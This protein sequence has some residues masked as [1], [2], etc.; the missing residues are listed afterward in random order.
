MVQ[1]YADLVSRS[2]CLFLVLIFRGQLRRS[3]GEESTALD[4]LEDSTI[5][6]TYIPGSRA[7]T[8]RWDA[9]NYYEHSYHRELQLT[10]KR[11]QQRSRCRTARIHPLLSGRSFLFPA[12]LPSSIF[13]RRSC[14]TST[15]TECTSVDCLCLSRQAASFFCVWCA[16]RA[17]FRCSCYPQR[18]GRER[19][20]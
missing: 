19:E 16:C 18:R 6:W 13:S 1:T 11:Q 15:R 20:H 3:R 14:E 4:A 8:G 9:E 2:A 17:A 7:C 10:S 12:S 5:T